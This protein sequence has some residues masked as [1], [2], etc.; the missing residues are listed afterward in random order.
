MGGKQMAVPKDYKYTRT[1]EWVKVDGDI[2]TIGITDFAQSELGDITYIE[3]PAVGSTLDKSDSLGVIESVKAASDVYAPISGEVVEDNTTVEEAP[4][5]VNSSPFEDAWLVKLRI[6][7]PS[8]LDE[9]LD[10][11]AYEA[12]LDE[13]GGH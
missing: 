2:A 11:D 8:Q 7:D 4:E 1:H 13:A 10:A 5:T 9:L 12:L 3:L 6:T